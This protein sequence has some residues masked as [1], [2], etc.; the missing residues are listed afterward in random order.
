[1]L[2][3]ESHLV[4]GFATG[5]TRPNYLASPTWPFPAYA[6][7][8]LS[9]AA[10]GTGITARGARA[11]RERIDVIGWRRFPAMWHGTAQTNVD[12]ARSDGQPW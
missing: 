4:L 5:C 12:C 9:M 2:F 8:F 10:F 11:F 7:W 1:L 3:A 6:R